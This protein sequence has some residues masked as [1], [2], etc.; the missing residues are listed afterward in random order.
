MKQEFTGHKKIIKDIAYASNGDFIVSGSAD[1]TLRKWSLRTLEEDIEISQP[2]EI[3]SVAISPDCQRIATGGISHA[4]I[5]DASSGA[6]LKK[7]EGTG[8]SIDGVAF[9]RDGQ[10]LYYSSLNGT[11][12]IWKYNELNQTLIT[13]KGLPV[14][15]KHASTL[16]QT[17]ILDKDMPFCVTPFWGNTL[18]STSDTDVHFID[19]ESGRI[20]F[21]LGAHPGE[22]K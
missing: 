9:S 18:F 22:G 20:L 21:R 7:S 13:V 11:V 6:I 15:S 19:A 1:Q 10:H 12:Y 14:S 16:T 4:W 3:S 5:F 17:L 2:Y 8:D